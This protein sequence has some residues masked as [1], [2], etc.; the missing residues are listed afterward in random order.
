MKQGTS[1]FSLAFSSISLGHSFRNP[2]GSRGTLQVM[3]VPLH[4]A[5]LC[6]K[7][8]S[9]SFKFSSNSCRMFSLH[10]SLFCKESKLYMY[11]DIRMW[12]IPSTLVWYWF[13]CWTHKV[14]NLWR[15]NITSSHFH[16][17][18]S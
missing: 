17:N 12:V 3:Q 14:Q 10:T 9:R 7:I 16:W 15:E 18:I 2:N 4:L 11:Q 5:T 8:S 1:C 6:F 13:L